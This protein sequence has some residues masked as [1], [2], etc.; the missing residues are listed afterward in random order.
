V[1]PLGDFIDRGPDSRQVIDMLIDLGGRCQLAP[2]IGN[3]EIMMLQ[4]I[5]DLSSMPFWLECGGLVTVDNYG[6]GMEEFP[7]D[8]VDFLRQCCRF[9]ETERHIFVHANYDPDLPLEA[10]P[11]QLLFWEHVIRTMPPPH[12]SGKIAIV[13]HTPQKSGEILNMDYLLCIDTYCV[14]DRWLTAVDV[15]NGTTW[16]TNQ[17]GELRIGSLT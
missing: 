7:N 14:G 6:G 1:I 2:L 16:Q 9:V 3:H 13:G 4:A 8:H 11:D 15:D 5:E 10:Q 17:Q 12:R